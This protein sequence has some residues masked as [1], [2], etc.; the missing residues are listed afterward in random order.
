MMETSNQKIHKED[1]DVAESNQN[2]MS[3]GHALIEVEEEK[4][5]DDQIGDDEDKEDSNLENQQ[6][7]RPLLAD[8]ECDLLPEA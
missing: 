3:F 8:A 7:F 6:S 2:E 1:I 5:S 4:H